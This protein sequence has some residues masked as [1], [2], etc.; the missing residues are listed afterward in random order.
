[1]TYEIN[2]TYNGFKLKK[3]YEIKEIDSMAHLFEHEKSGAELLYLQ[4][5]DDNKVFSVAFR[6]PP[7][8]STGVPHIVEHCV[9]SGSRKYKT[10]EPFMDM[11]KGSLKTF[12]N[13]MT[14]SDKTI[15]PVASRND[16]DFFNLMDVYLDSVYFPMIYDEPEIFMQEG[17]HYDIH[18]R[19]DPL[20]CTGVV[21]NEMLGAYST[22]ETVLD[23]AINESLYPD[24]CYNFSSGGNPDVIPNLTFEDFTGF[25]KKYYHPSNSYIYIYGDGDIDK[26]LEHINEDYL[27]HFDKS[28]VDSTIEL[29]APLSSPSTNVQFYP[30]SDDENDE[31]KDY[32][33]LSYNVGLVTDPIDHLTAQ[34]LKHA[35]ISSTAAPVKKALLDAGIGEDISSSMT[36]GVH[37]GLSIIAKNTSET[38]KDD[39]ENVVT[40]TLMQL[41]QSGIDKDLIRSSINIVE[42]DMREASRFATK[43]IIY[44]INSMQSW[45]YSDD[46]T[47]Y[48]EYN[49]ILEKLNHLL[50]TDHYEN[51]VKERILG[52]PHASLVVLKPQ[53]GLGEAKA[54][55]LSERLQAYKESLSEEALDELIEMNKQLQEKQLSPDSEENL[56]TIPKLDVSD[57]DPVVEKIPQ[58]IEQRD[59]YTLLHHDIFANDIGYAD[60]M[61]D[62]ST[63]P[64][65][66]VPYANLMTFLVT[67]LDTQDRSYADLTK[68]IYKYTG[69]ISLQSVIYPAKDTD[70]F[71][72]PRIAV[73]TKAIGSQIS[74]INE[75]LAEVLLRTDFSD[76][77]RMKELIQQAKSRIEMNIIQSGNSVAGRRAMSYFSP[78]AKYTEQLTGLDFYWFLED[79]LKDYDAFSEKLIENLK[80]TYCTIFNINNL[81]ISFTGAKKDYKAFTSNIEKLT[82]NLHAEE[83]PFQTFNFSYNQVNEGIPTSGNVQYVAKASNYR[84][85][86][87]D[88]HGSINVLSVLLN[89]E[90]LHDR[91]RAKGGAYGCHISASHTGNIQMVSYRDPNLVETLDVYNTV[92]DYIENIDLTDKDLTKYIIGA[93]SK[94]DGAL[95]PH[96]KGRTATANFISDTSYEELQLE[97]DQIIG[98]SSSELKAFSDLIRK[99]MADDFKCVLGNDRKIK[100]HKDIFDHIVPLKNR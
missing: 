70:Q 14:F 34:I 72:Y 46:P 95:T 19:K 91:V 58:E 31:N 27:K 92:A 60:F 90:F 16:K 3:K 21:Y 57:V 65:D 44:H 54:T 9:L 75:L 7:S 45:L 73:R 8:D 20:K 17:W 25:H 23:D 74:K 43:G 59:A 86:G 33:A 88:Y 26:Y 12:I 64:I 49:P 97:R 79:L 62:L 76:T 53:K 1:M 93:I 37:C 47:V 30:L 38:R 51:F 68:E 40:T 6:T 69:G 32:L 71:F 100:E 52:N 94:Q 36:D 78:I 24:T 84:K 41:V 48:L 81:V 83:L 99:T 89:S 11:V 29:Q 13:A 55:A 10:K 67:K 42:Y 5:D 80:K 87:F 39:F 15:Y 2:K 4:N 35:L 56:A 66:L 96:M 98:T 18:D 22:P 85:H 63:L 77:K 50:D 61:F 28:K 82:D